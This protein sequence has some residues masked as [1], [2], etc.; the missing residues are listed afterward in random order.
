MNKFLTLLALGILL[1]QYSYAQQLRGICGTSI[2]DN[3]EIRERMLKNRAD[4]EGKLMPR[5]GAKTYIPVNYWLIAKNDGTGRLPFKN[6]IDNLCA[7]NR[8]YADMDFVFY[9]NLAKNENNTAVYDD[10][11]STLGEAY[12]RAWML[13]NKNA[14]NI[15]V[16]STA[17]ASDPSVLAFYNRLG[18]YIVSG[19]NYVNADGTTLAHEIGHYFS[20]AH[21]FFGWEST[22]YTDVTANC[23]KPTPSIVSLG[24]GITVPVEYV[25][26][27]KA[28]SGGKK[29]CAQSADGF[30]DTPPDYNLGLGWTGG[31]NYNG[32]AKDPD[33][34]ALDPMENN[35][36][37]YFLNCI[38][39]YTPDQKD[40]ILK[41]YLSSARNY[42][43]RTPDYSP[44]P[45]VTDVLNYI[46]PSDAFPPA[47]YDII[48]FD[49]D[50][51]PNA[52]HYIFEVAENTGFNINAQ[53][54]V[55]THS[56]TT[57][58]NLRKNKT[59]YWR[60]TPFNKNSFCLVA[61]LATFKTPNWTVSTD[62]LSSDKMSSY[63]YSTNANEEILVI[64]SKLTD[65][66]SLKILNT[67][68][69]IVEHRTVSIQ[70]GINTIN[71]SVTQSGLFIYQLSSNLN[72]MHSG[73]FVKP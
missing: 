5:S 17:R 54:Y 28:G 20:L 47:G 43:R 4:W 56:D 19:K 41:D 8:I 70:H 42:L 59:H 29:H 52:T 61:K 24:G 65:V 68:G 16:A 11:S 72:G 64:D 15:F 67:Q 57:L 37:S 63:V 53:Q 50:D 66:F 23:T 39:I 27:E 12:I 9:L 13:A 40:A 62:E 60:V 30:C 31:C 38:A 32:C 34:A 45:E 55:L 1:C 21:T 36:M 71:L 48:S 33:N 73:K 49:W 46:T 3:Y 22:V 14:I 6:V 35:L 69:K 7:L 2:E 51:V 18:D 58:T 44:F 26:R 10:P 25:D